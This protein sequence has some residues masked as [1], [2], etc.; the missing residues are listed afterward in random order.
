VDAHARPRV[1]L[2]LSQAQT[3]LRIIRRILAGHGIEPRAR[4]NRKTPPRQLS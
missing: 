1:A 3:A 2:S 4:R